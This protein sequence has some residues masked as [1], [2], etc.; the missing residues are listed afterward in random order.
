MPD[1]LSHVCLAWLVGRG[2]RLR[3]GTVALIIGTFLP[4]FLTAAPAA[5]VGGYW[6]F[7][8]AHTPVGV[9]VWAYA[10]S[11]LFRQADRR[12]V[13]GCLVGGGWLA[14][15][16]DAL[17]DHVGGGYMLLFPFSWAEFEAHL[18]PPEAS[19]FWL[20]LLLAAVAL[21]EAVL[22]FRRRTPQRP[23][24]PGPAG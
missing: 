4:D 5:V 15:A 21:V 14:L 16:L 2:L 9:L 12:L 23:P 1:P 8:P 7:G 6:F 18:I 17:Q 13:F 20:P 22:W 11:L 10:G 24:P 3:R 19:L